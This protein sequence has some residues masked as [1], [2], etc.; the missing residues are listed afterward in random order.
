MG[1]PSI[2][3]VSVAIGQASV[4]QL[5][6]QFDT[7]AGEAGATVRAPAFQAS[8]PKRCA[9][10]SCPLSEIGIV[11]GCSFRLAFC[12]IHP[13]SGVACNG[14]QRVAASASALWQHG[15]TGSTSHRQEAA[16]LES[17]FE[18]GQREVDGGCMATGSAE[19]HAAIL[20]SGSPKSYRCFAP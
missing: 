8:R 14:G 13:C 9:S 20:V 11:I 6:L 10:P 1:D 19:R 18:D 17:P 2:S 5:L 15:Q 4:S 3:V 16:R 12:A 7:G